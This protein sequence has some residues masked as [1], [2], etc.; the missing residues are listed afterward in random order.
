MPTKEPYQKRTSHGMILGTNGEKMSKS[1]G[2][3][4]NPDDIV[5]NYGAD[6]LRIY[7]MFMGP[8]CDSKPWSETG[9]EG[10]KRFLDRFFRLFSDT[11][12]VCDKPNTNLEKEYHKTVKKVT[13]D[14]EKLSFNTAIS[15]IMIFVNSA[16][17]EDFVPREFAEGIIKLL[18]PIAPHITEEL[19][20]ILGHNQTIANEPW[21]TFDE[22]KTVDNTIN[23][24]VQINGKLKGTIQ[25]ELDLP[26]E[27]VKTLAHEKVANLLDGKTIVKEIY[28]K[29]R[30]YNIVVK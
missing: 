27:T 26:E 23:L 2:N 10:A 9:I 25:I 8:L 1:R 13:A 20:N 21:P 28:V 7:E 3:V 29:N 5:K 4:I 18:N 6:S 11:S 15:Q 30:I 24:P 17:K 19:W 14:Y 22:A 16:Y 12:K